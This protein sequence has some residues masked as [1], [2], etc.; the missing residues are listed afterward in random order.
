MRRRDPSS[1]PVS[2]PSTSVVSFELERHATAGTIQLLLAR[3][4]GTVVPVPADGPPV[5]AGRQ[6]AAPGTKGTAW[7]SF[8]LP[9]LDV[10]SLTQPPTDLLFGAGDSTHPVIGE[11]RLWQ[12]SGAAGQAAT[13]GLSR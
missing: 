8:A 7:V 11:I 1:D 9:T 4:D 3:D 6:I 13:A 5:P 2:R 12:A 10:P